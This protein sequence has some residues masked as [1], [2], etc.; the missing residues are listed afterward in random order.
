MA[1]KKVVD[2]VLRPK[3][4]I[5]LP[6]EVCEQLGIDTGDMLEL[7]LEGS[8]V[9]ARP[10]KVAALNALREIQEAFKRSGIG[11][12]ELGETGRKVRQEVVRERHAAGL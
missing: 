12:E 7:A 9:V 5:T 11:E 10:K 1:E 2:V 4:Q 3:R 8:T 6:K